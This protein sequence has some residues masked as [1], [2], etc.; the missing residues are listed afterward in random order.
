MVASTSGDSHSTYS[1]DRKSSKVLPLRPSEASL[2]TIPDV[3]D[4]SRLK[5]SWDALIERRFL[6]P[7]PLSILP[8][9]LSSIFVDL[10]SR[11][12][13]RVS[14]PPNSFAVRA[15]IQAASG[16]S[17]SNGFETYLN[18]DEELEGQDQP[19]ESWFAKTSGLDR[20]SDVYGLHEAILNEFKCSVDAT[21]PMHLARTVS[22]VEH[23]KDAMWTEYKVLYGS[24]PA[25]GDNTLR[26]DFEM[27]WNNWKK[28]MFPLRYIY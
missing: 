7:Q 16:L 17:S 22:I 1:A 3:R 28:Y 23:C 4:H 19:Q 12:T 18:G 26:E 13:L 27:Y 20:S 2:V 21:A 8:L 10:Q 6:A 15:S 9:Y 14:L 24:L 5:A 25:Y 11:P